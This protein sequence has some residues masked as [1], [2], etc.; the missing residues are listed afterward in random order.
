MDNTCEN[1]FYSNDGNQGLVNFISRDFR[2][3]L[4][5]GCGAGD[6]AALLQTLVPGAQVYGITLSEAEQRQAQ[7]HMEACLCAD[8]EE[9]IPSKIRSRDFDLVLFSHVLEH[10]RSPSLV[11]ENFA[12][13]LCPRGSMFIAV[14]NVLVWSVRLQFLQGHFE[15]SESGHLD[16]THL[17]FYT[18]Y[19]VDELI[20]QAPSIRLVRKKASGHVPLGPMR[21]LLSDEI[22]GV[23]DR[24]GT[25]AWP[26][27][28][29]QQILVEARHAQGDEE[30]K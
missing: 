24:Y 16:R 8:V 1:K 19:T 13:V 2:H 28:F 11:L 7:E 12:D 9:G 3:V 20:D 29:G 4:D 23:V 21:R 18:Y 5:V 26:N 15:Y 6:N 14:P 25:R 30:V 27:L 22:T 10:L 17:R